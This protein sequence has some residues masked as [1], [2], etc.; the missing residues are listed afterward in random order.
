[1]KKIIICTVLAVCMVTIFL[2]FRNKKTDSAEQMED[3]LSASLDAVIN[4]TES[5]KLYIYDAGIWNNLTDTGT[6]LNAVKKQVTY[7]IV[8]LNEGKA[9]I[10][11]TA[12][13]V[14]AILQSAASAG[15]ADEEELMDTL[16][17]A[18][19]NDFPVKEFDVEIQLNNIENH[20]YMVPND[21]LNNALSGGL[22]EAYTN[23]IRSR[24]DAQEEN[25]K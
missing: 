3:D 20:W 10:L 9:K 5:D 15:A 19:Q 23:E 13:D 16:N 4:E 11:F 18:L 8:E 25:S 12:P 2:C 17:D 22:M 21:K 1:M 7:E 6:G 24:I 14:I